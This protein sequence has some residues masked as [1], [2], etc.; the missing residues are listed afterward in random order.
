M[1]KIFKSHSA[2]GFFQ[3]G[4]LPSSF[5]RLSEHIAT[6]KLIGMRRKKRQTIL[7]GMGACD[8]KLV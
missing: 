7:N 2:D 8:L 1:R 5:K 3:Y 6:E 4:A